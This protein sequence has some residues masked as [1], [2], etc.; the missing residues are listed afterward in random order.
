MSFGHWSWGQRPEAARV[1]LG[2]GAGVLP[3]VGGGGSGGQGSGAA[4]YAWHRGRI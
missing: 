4:G 3:G 1:L 2:E